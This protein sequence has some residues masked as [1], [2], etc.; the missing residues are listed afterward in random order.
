MDPRTASF[1]RHAGEL[2]E[3]GRYDEAAGL[4]R[5]ARDAAARAGD[6]P[7]AVLAWH[8]QV[9]RRTFLQARWA[10]A[11]T[12][13]RAAVALAGPADATPRD[14]FDVEFRL[15][16]VLQR[17]ERTAEAIAQLERTLA[18]AAGLGPAFVAP[19]AATRA[20]AASLRAAG[21]DAEADRLEA[22]LP[23]PEIPA[24]ATPAPARTGRPLP[25]PLA[26]PADD[27]LE[28]V[29]RDLDALIGLAAA[30]AQFRRLPSCCASTSCA[31][32]T[33]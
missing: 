16:L 7:D 10:E 33:A 9:A 26:A 11:E 27:S 6:P 22:V 23:A 15:G 2:T 31:A 25:P 19:P 12:A 17:Q 8:V 20:L 30:K 5:Q 1:L 13:L 18:L 14:R 29:F 24:P 3:L 21:R 32:A 28:A 4:E